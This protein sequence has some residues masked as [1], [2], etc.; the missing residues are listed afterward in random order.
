MD[1]T[2]T[3][4]I[5]KTWLH[6]ALGAA[7]IWIGIIGLGGIVSWIRSI[8]RQNELVRRLNNRNPD[9]WTP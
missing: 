4:P 1:I 3:Y 8:E 6:I 2:W 7:I 9:D 5:I